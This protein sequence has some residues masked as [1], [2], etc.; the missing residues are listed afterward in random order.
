MQPTQAALTPAPAATATPNEPQPTST[1]VPAPPDLTW[2]QIGP[3]GGSEFVHDSDGEIEH[4]VGFDAGYLAD[5]QIVG[6]EGQW[7]SRLW[8][9]RDGRDWQIVD[10]FDQENDI[11]AMATNGREVVLLVETS[12]YTTAAW[13][14]SNGTDWREHG[15]ISSETA[16]EPPIARAVWTRPGGWYAAMY[17]ANDES[18]D[19]PY[20]CYRGSL[21]SSDDGLSW[22]RLAVIDQE[23]PLAGATAADGTVLVITLPLHASRD[24]GATWRRQRTP[25]SCFASDMP[26]FLVPTQ[27]TAEVL[28]YG[29]GRNV[30]VGA[31]DLRDWDRVKLPTTSTLEPFRSTLIQSRFGILAAAERDCF[32][33]PCPPTIEMFQ[34]HDGRH[35]SILDG[36]IED[37]HDASELTFADGPGGVIG[38]A[39]F[40][41]SGGRTVMVY[42]LLQIN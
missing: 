17:E 23:D 20:G 31:A 29:G 18:C 41:G 21:W 42:E 12:D 36:P 7:A 30:C 2:Q 11:R 1:P 16:S 35:W 8:F 26:A 25:R 34:S 5:Q 38:L 13:L 15:T 19:S 3:L 27:L 24:G 32:E 6:S 28:I 39:S 40:T 4:L 14:T 10:Q 22:E 37:L 9:S 33:T